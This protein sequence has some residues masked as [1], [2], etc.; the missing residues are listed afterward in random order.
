MNTEQVSDVLAKAFKEVAPE[1]DFKSLDLKQPLWRQ[2]EIDS[3]DIYRILM[4]LDK[5]TGIKVPDSKV[6]SFENLEALIQ[7]ITEQPIHHQ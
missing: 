1:I 5:Q 4:I 2:V 6:R 7:F 3:M